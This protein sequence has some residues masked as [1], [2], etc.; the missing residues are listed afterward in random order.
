MASLAGLVEDNSGDESE[1]EP[2]TFEI[3]PDHIMSKVFN[4]A[5]TME[6][7]EF[8]NKWSYDE[9]I[10][11]Q[12]V[13]IEFEYE[14]KDGSTFNDYFVLTRQ[15][16]NEHIENGDTTVEIR[17]VGKN[18][19]ERDITVNLLGGELYTD[20]H[21]WPD[22]AAR[23]LTERHGE[24]FRQFSVTKY[25]YIGEWLNGQSED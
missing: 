22:H 2:K 20:F 12:I 14:F 10:F 23:F 3:L 1:D 6:K 21:V 24:N 7:K 25:E 5:N 9:K 17:L 19:T 15:Q 13:P 4:D 11:E 18:S 16:F 8:M